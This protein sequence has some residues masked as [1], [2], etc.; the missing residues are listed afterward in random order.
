MIASASKQAAD[1]WQ[2][3]APSIT[4]TERRSD[5]VDTVHRALAQPSMTAAY[6]P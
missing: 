5:R 1:T 4:V 2:A 6:P 3:T